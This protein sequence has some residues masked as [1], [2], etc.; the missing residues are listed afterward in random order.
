[1]KNLT[2][3]TIL[4][5]VYL[6]FAIPVNAQII[7]GGKFS[8]FLYTDFTVGKVTLK[9]GKTDSL[10]LNY[11]TLTEKMMYLKDGI[12]YDI[13]NPEIIDTIFLNQTKFVQKEF[14]FF[15]VF[16]DA[17]VSFYIQYK[18]KLLPSETRSV[19][20]LRSQIPNVKIKS[21]FE[22]SE[23]NF[24]LDHLVRIDLIYW[25]KIFGKMVRFTNKSE[26]LKLYPIRRQEMKQFIKQEQVQFDKPSD[27][28]KLAKYFNIITL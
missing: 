9:T 26:F 1:M 5:L 22:T 7:S 12:L 25:V 15:E 28:K 2:A 17:P 19:Y 13:V 27:I 4:F 18:G 8:Q 6:N 23:G 14:V 11:N 16:F 20:G 3:V 10:M 21:S 24:N